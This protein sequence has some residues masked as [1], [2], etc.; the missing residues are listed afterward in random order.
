MSVQNGTCHIKKSLVLKKKTD[1]LKNTATFTSN[2]AF[3][4]IGI[5]T[6]H[7]KYVICRNMLINDSLRLCFIR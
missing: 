5:K 6:L 2:L 7:V 3:N 1:V 4:L